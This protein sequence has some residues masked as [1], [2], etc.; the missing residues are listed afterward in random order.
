MRLR[1]KRI[2]GFL[3]VVLLGLTAL[4]HEAALI[5]APPMVPSSLPTMHMKPIHLPSPSRSLPKEIAGELQLMEI[6]N[7]QV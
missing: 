1:A 7:S 4:P 5:N 6:I 3:F 2:W